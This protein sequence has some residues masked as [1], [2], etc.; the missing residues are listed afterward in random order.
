MIKK[1]EIINK[2]H[3]STHCVN[4]ILKGYEEKQ[5]PER[6]QIGKK[7]DIKDIKSYKKAYRLRINRLHPLSKK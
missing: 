4:Q 3:R 6:R 7:S 1:T 2:K 5:T